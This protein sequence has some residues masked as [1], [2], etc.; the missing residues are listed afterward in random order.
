MLLGEFLLLLWL[1]MTVVGDSAG[2]SIVV[3]LLLTVITAAG[4]TWDQRRRRA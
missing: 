1:G 2:R 4:V 3:A